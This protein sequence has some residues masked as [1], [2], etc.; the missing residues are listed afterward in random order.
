MPK[1]EEYGAQPPLELL[2]QLK[3]EDIYFV[4]AMGP[5]G[6]GRAV[7]T[8][9]LQRHFNIMTYT[10]LQAESMDTIFNTILTAF[11]FNFTTEIKEAIEPLIAMTLSV[12][13]KVLNGPLKPTPSRSHYLFNLRD[14]SRIT[15][16]LCRADKRECMAPI[17]I[18]RMWV[19][20]NHR[21]FSDRLIDGKDRKWMND[22]LEE[23][24]IERF[25]L[26]KDEVMNAERIIY[27][28]YMEGIDVETRTY[29]QITDLK[30]FVT[31][32]EEYL[33]EYNSAVKTQMNLVMFLDACDHVSRIARVLSQPLGNSLLLG[34]GGSG[35]QSLARLATFLANYKL[36]QIEVIKGYG[37]QNWRD[38][39]KRALLQ[40]GIEN[41]PTSFLFVDTQIVNE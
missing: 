30:M 28:D 10:D 15:Q 1:K 8:A 33:E 23:E 13:D 20:E 11:Y 3:I 26:E 2:R 14:I 21:V 36:F 38:D 31:K 27:G 16:G 35:R 7:I 18:V 19:H 41:K 22:V 6:G 25:K 29:K 34:V 24:F 12:Y 39:A 40:A 17:D 37:M 9:R 5:P 32:V 4:A